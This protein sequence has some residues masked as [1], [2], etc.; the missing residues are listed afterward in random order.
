MPVQRVL[1]INQ[2]ITPYLEASYMSIIGRY[3]P[4]SIQEKGVEVRTFM[5]RYGVINE[6][7]NQLHS[8]IRL[9]G[10]NIVI[11]NNDHTL[12]LKV[13]SIQSIRMQTYFIDN[14]EF[15]K[16]RV[17]LHDKMGNFLPDNDERAIFYARGVIETVKKLGWSPDIIH[18]QGWI[19]C[20]VPIFMKKVYVDNPLFS[21]TKIV[22][23]IYNDTFD[24]SFRFLASKLKASEVPPKDATLYRQASF[25]STMKLAANYSDA[26]IVSHKDV[27]EEIRSYVANSKKPY[28]EHQEEQYGDSYFN[29]YNS[30]L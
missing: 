11:N 8:V 2:E 20:L 28:F 16:K 18:C 9:S 4:Q 7:R 10:Q 29:L 26:V 17:L 5:P 27:S 22:Y 25:E 19:S 14:E 6:R 23:S 15:F 3:L 1:F 12:V 24:K 21:N 13:A 30:L